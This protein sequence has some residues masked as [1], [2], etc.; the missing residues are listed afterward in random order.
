MEHLRFQTWT[1]RLEHPDLNNL[2]CLMR[3]TCPSARQVWMETPT[4]HGCHG[5]THGMPEA[6][7]GARHSRRGRADFGA[8]PSGK[9]RHFLLRNDG[10]RC[11]EKWWDWDQCMSIMN[12]FIWSS[13]Y[14][15]RHIP[16]Y[17]YIYVC[18]CAR[19]SACRCVTKVTPVGFIWN[20]LLCRSAIPIHPPD[21]ARR[22]QVIRIIDS[23]EGRWALLTVKVS[24]PSGGGK[25]AQKR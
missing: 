2:K 6:R 8:F 5:M 20:H 14:V 1:S 21:S 22:R 15:Y 17:I 16:I 4:T 10:W 24:P 18:V 9:K 25:F 19:V 7:I 12:G 13:I 23:L 11:A 3:L